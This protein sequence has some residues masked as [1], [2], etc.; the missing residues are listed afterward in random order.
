MSEPAKKMASYEDLYSVPDDLV[1]EII[2]GELVATPRPSVRHALASSALGGKLL[3][4]YHL[5]EGG[6]PGGWVILSE[7]EIKLGDN[8]LVPDLAGWRKER[9]PGLPEENWI[10]VPPDWICE[11]LSPRTFR[12][13]K[14]QKMPIYARHQVQHLWMI[15]PFAKSLEVFRLEGGK[16]YLMAVFTENDSVRAEPFMEVEIDLANLWWETAQ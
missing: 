12:V 1:G 5:G 11:I 6:G 16:W 10:A 2:D 3:P 13:D 7:T 15:D 4:P 8:L 14:V 9:F